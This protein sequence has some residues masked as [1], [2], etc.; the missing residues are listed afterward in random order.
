[1]KSRIEIKTQAK[2]IL[3]GNYGMCLAP[4]LIYMLLSMVASSVTLGL[5]SL[6]IIPIAVGMN[7]VYL[8]HWKGENPPLELM[9][10][11]AF[12]EN[13]LRKLG[14]MLLVSLYTYLWSLLFIIPGIVKA[15][16]YAMTPYILAKFPNVDAVSAI[17]ISRRI[18]NG[19]KADLFVVDLSFIGWNLLS[20][21]TFGILQI[22]Y[23]S[24]YQMITRA[25]CFDEYLADALENGRI[26]LDE[27]KING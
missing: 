2:S 21:L 20:V 15:Y 13:F 9:F 12:Q 25:G 22:F 8:M 18:M 7:L 1:M 16:A 26:S 11:S 6:L 17:D 3:H 5:G 24:P 14:S 10:T 23:V 19:R 27:L 4:C